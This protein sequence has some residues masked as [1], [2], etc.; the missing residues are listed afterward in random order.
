[1]LRPALVEYLYGRDVDLT[2][3]ADHDLVSSA[4]AF[5]KNVPAAK[6][7]ILNLVTTEAFVTRLP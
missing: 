7:L 2:V 6:N 5:S 3:A 4:G 1:L